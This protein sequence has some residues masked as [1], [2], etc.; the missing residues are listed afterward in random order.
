M[1]QRIIPYLPDYVDLYYV[2][3]RD[4]LSNH[5]NLIQ[6]CLE[7]NGLYPLTECMD[8][9]WDFPEGP[10]IDEIRNSMSDEFEDADDIV[11]NNIDEIREWLWEHDTST[12]IEDLLKNT[13]VSFFYSLG[14]ELDCGWQSDFFVPPYQNETYASALSRACHKLGIK[15]DSK[16]YERL[17]Q[18]VEQ[19][20]GGE[21]RIY[22]E[23]D[24]Q[25]LINHDNDNDFK[26][27]RF[28]GQFLIGIINPYEGSG[29]CDWFDL[30]LEFPFVRDNIFVSKCERYGLEEIFGQWMTRDSDEPELLMTKPKTR[31]QIKIS[32]TSHLLDLEK[33][34]DATF[35]A[36]GCTAGD[37]DLRRHRDVYYRNDLPCG[38]KCPHCGQFWI[39]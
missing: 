33:E 29:D 22:W 38:L 2:D 36:G 27:I 20:N 16:Y 5:M 14:E 17:M 7:K 34:Y 13:R 6:D 35:K 19:S 15:K 24:V 30:D 25:K 23:G 18:V 8:E 10:Y 21:L 12:P 1:D 11:D 9:W 32:N 37:T 39:D 3:Y 28:K 4:D 26:T 31:K